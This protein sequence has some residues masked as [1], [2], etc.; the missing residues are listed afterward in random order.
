L[1]RRVVRSSKAP[2]PIGPYNQGILASGTFLFVAGQGS[3]DPTTGTAPAEFRDRVARCIENV[4]AVVEEAGA[5]LADVVRVGVFL[6]DMGKFKEFNEVYGSYFRDPFPART[7]VQAV[8][9]AG[10]DVEIDAV[11]VLK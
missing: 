1:T 4:K 5:T 2:A 10:T 11:A 7:T 9:P 8:L 3:K 6:A